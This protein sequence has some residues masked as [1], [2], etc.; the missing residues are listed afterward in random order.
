MDENLKTAI[1][2]ALINIGNTEEGKAGH[3]NLLQTLRAALL[4]TITGGKEKQ[5]S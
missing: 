3:R 2:T 5:Y 1:Q 4:I